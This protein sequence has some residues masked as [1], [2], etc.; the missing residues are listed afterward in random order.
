MFSEET[1][2]HILVQYVLAHCEAGNVG[3]LALQFQF[4]NFPYGMA[5]TFKQPTD[6]LV[7]SSFVLKVQSRLALK[8]SRYKMSF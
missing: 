4:E 2:L 7:T 1:E 5:L 8:G 3:S 6:Q